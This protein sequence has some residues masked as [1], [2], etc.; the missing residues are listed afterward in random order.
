MPKDLSAAL[1]L[2][3]IIEGLFLLAA[4]GMWQRMAE[5]LRKLDERSLRMCGGLMVGVGLLVLKLVY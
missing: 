5:Q 1:C 4:P 3:L 2:M